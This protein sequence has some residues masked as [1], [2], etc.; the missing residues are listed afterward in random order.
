MNRGNDEYFNDDDGEDIDGDK[1][2]DTLVGVNATM[3][4]LFNN[5]PSVFF[6]GKTISWT[7]YE[8]TA[9]SE[10]SSLFWFTYRDN[11]PAI[12]PYGITTDAGWG[13]MLR[14][15][16][17]LLA[18][19]LR[20]HF[21]SRHWRP[22]RG[23]AFVQ[24][25][26]TWFADY[27][28]KSNSV[29]SLHNLCAAGLQYQVLPGEWVGPNTASYVLRDLVELHH[30]T[31]PSLFRVHVSSEGTVYEQTVHELMTRDARKRRNETE[32]INQQQ[33]QQSEPEQGDDPL[34]HPLDSTPSDST[35]NDSKNR[36][37]SWEWVEEWDTSLL[38][39]IPLRLGLDRFNEDYV[40]S[41]ARTFSL[42]QSVGVLGGRPRGARWF[43]GAY[44]NGSKVLGLDPHTIQ[45]TL[46]R[47]GTSNLI[48]LSEEYRS[49]YFTRYPEVFDLKRMDPSLAL[50]F[51]CENR[52]DFES[53]KESLSRIHLLRTTTT[54]SQHH[55]NGNRFNNS[56]SSSTPPPVLVSFLDKAPDYEHDG[57]M[58]N[59][60]E[61]EEDDMF[62]GGGSGDNRVDDDSDDDEY[63]ML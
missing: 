53:L 20:I 7:D 60:P 63:V 62:L 30:K 28:S 44:S 18:H 14:S 39:L 25:L 12:Q 43:Y 8:T 46:P 21:Q 34:L 48:D 33:K 57:A 10:A 61:D 55:Q 31:Q 41:L 35:T 58:L 19:T 2:V 13:C 6:L 16:Q 59:E 47:V 45:A 17:M 23:D 24:T 51:Y 32:L 36:P 42:P 56:S 37:S 11:F 4:G 22:N 5:T 3:K 27:P 54:T 52:K 29:Y 1:Q 50:G 9:I 15:A 26:L 38:L 49:S 40:H